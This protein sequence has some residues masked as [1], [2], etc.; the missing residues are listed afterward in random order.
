MSDS[1]TDWVGALEAGDSA[2]AGRLWG[3]YFM[4]LVQLARRNLGRH[5][6]PCDAEDVALS[7]FKSLCL[8]AERGALDVGG[9][10]ELWRL[11]VVM[12]R[13]KS[14]DRLREAGRQKRG[15]LLIHHATDSTGDLDRFEADD[16]TPEE[17]AE[18]ADEHR[19]MLAQLDTDEQRAVVNLKLEGYENTEIA[20]RLG[21]SLRSVERKLQMIRALWRRELELP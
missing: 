17:L 2:A 16:P 9:R 6:G 4:K 19:R 14:V 1:V 7:V 3:R 11:L 15:G 20:S 18:L 12:T 21:L 8:G 5:P 13:R 10:D